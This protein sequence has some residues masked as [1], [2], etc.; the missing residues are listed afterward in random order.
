MRIDYHIQKSKKI[1]G[2]GENF[3]VEPPTLTIAV[4]MDDDY[5]EVVIPLDELKE[6]MEKA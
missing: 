5:S 2:I 1:Q 3:Y 4:I 6:A